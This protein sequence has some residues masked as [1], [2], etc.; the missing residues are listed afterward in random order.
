MNITTYKKEIYDRKT[1]IITYVKSLKL[2]FPL[3]RIQDICLKY[4][5]GSIIKYHV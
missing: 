1:K 4:E 2:N 3:D 5:A